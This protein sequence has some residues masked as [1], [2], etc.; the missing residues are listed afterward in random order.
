GLPHP[1]E[2]KLIEEDEIAR[3]PL[4]EER[5]RRILIAAAATAALGA[6]VRILES[7]S[8][9]RWARKGRAGV[10]PAR[11]APF[12]RRSS[13]PSQVENEPAPGPETEQGGQGQ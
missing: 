11:P 5:R 7:R 9:G 13:A 12:L 1:L 6:P 4:T 10:Q 2:A 8:A 3:T